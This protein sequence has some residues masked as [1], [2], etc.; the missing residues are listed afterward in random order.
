M[1]ERIKGR[2]FIDGLE[3]KDINQVFQRLF[4]INDQHGE[5][6]NKDDWNLILKH[7]K[8]ESYLIPPMSEQSDTKETYYVVEKFDRYVDGVFTVYANDVAYEKQLT[9]TKSLLDCDRYDTY[10]QAKEFADKYNCN[11]R[12]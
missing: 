8:C 12:K 2:I 11:V 4:N 3:L 6:L 10:E 9:T 5:Q 7:T 1:D